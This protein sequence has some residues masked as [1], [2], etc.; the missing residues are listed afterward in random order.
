M[1]M[2]E[3]EEDDDADEGRKIIIRGRKQLEER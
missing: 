1:M 2:E 3:G